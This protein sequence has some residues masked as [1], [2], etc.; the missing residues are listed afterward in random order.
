MDSS[1]TQ[2]NE[3]VKD[4]NGINFDGFTIKV[5]R[6]TSVPD[7]KESHQFQEVGTFKLFISQFN[8]GVTKE[9]V[10]QMFESYGRIVDVEIY[11]SNS[12]FVVGFLFELLRRSVSEPDLSMTLLDLNSIWRRK[13]QEEHF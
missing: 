8:E 3:A 6:S 13:L 2:G 4:L 11:R 7:Q 12:A 9:E 5:Q 10:R 1:T